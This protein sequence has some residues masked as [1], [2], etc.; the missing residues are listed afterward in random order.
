MRARSRSG[1]CRLPL[2]PRK[3]EYRFVGLLL[4]RWL[5]LSWWRSTLL[6]LDQPVLKLAM[7]SACCAE[8]LGQ[9]T[10]ACIAQFL[11][12]ELAFA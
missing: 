8:P 7:L 5:K 10:A 2:V 4:Q 12:V 1:R 9:H 6:T 11:V 3:N